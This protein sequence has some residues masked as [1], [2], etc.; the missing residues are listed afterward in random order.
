M[1][2]YI[3]INWI[4]RGIL[5]V[6]SKEMQNSTLAL[7]LPSFN[8][9]LIGLKC[10]QNF[11]S[12][13]CLINDD[14]LILI[15]KAKERRVVLLEKGT[16]SNR[17]I[18]MVTLLRPHLLVFQWGTSTLPSTLVVFACF[19]IHWMTHID[20]WKHD[21]ICFVVILPILPNDAPHLTK[22]FFF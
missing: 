10:L 19:R 15:A 2:L 14:L 3:S 13:I 5:G 8:N 21:A 11:L 17:S 4:L 20:T 7:L 18:S 22:K 9:D 12:F 1:K 6:S 16:S